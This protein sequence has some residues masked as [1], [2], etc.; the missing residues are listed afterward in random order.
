MF[1]V[2][3]PLAFLLL[4]ICLS[5]QLITI[6]GTFKGPDGT[7]LNGKVTISMAR[8]TVTN[9]CVSPVQITS[10][11]QVIVKITNGTLGSLQLYASTCLQPPQPCGANGLQAGCYQIAVYNSSNVL[12]Y[13]GHWRVANSSPQDVVNLGEN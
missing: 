3:K 6:S 12:M 4:P 5:A 8:A 7:A 1:G 2:L 13:R 9:S 10:F 11:R